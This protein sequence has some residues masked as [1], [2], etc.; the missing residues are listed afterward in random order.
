MSKPSQS[1]R[2]VTVMDPQFKDKRDKSG[3]PARNT[4]YFEQTTDYEQGVKQLADPEIE[5]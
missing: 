3:Q 2:D 1:R 5:P 4:N